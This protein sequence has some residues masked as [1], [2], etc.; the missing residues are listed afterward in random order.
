M[1]EQYYLLTTDCVKCGH[2]EF[3]SFYDHYEP[4]EVI[5][6]YE[7][8]NKTCKSDQLRVIASEPE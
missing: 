7:C 6:G 2:R 3:F 1:K 4:G 8:T 5:Q